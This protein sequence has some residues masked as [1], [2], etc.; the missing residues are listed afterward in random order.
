[1]MIISVETFFSLLVL[2]APLFMNKFPSTMIF[3]FHSHFRFCLFC[4]INFFF[5]IKFSFFSLFFHSH[6]LHVTLISSSISV[7]L[8]LWIFLYINSNHH[9]FKLLLMNARRWEEEAKNQR[10][11]CGL[12]SLLY[13]QC[14]YMWM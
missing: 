2:F 5:F 10:W 4:E 3:N 9:K 8:S 12:I 7:Y 6:P 1:L 11:I 13:F 14:K